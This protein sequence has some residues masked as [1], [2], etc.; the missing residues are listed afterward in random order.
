MA[1]AHIQSLNGGTKQHH[2]AK[3]QKA[4]R[5]RNRR[6][7]LAV[8]KKSNQYFL[9]GPKEGRNRRVYVCIF[10]EGAKGQGKYFTYN[11]NPEEAWL[12]SE[13]LTVS[14]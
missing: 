8:F 3:K 14:L 12:P 10:D 11:S 13:D 9:D 7:R 4:D 2:N 1:K 5:E 6:A